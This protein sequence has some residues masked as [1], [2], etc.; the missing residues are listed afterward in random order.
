MFCYHFAGIEFHYWRQ[1]RPGQTI[2]FSSVCKNG[3][4]VVV[5]AKYSLY[6]VNNTE[7]TASL[8]QKQRRSILRMKC[9]V[10]MQIKPDMCT[11]RKVPWRQMLSYFWQSRCFHVVSG[12]CSDK[13][14][15]FPIYIN[16]ISNKNHQHLY[17]PAVVQMYLAKDLI[18]MQ[19]HSFNCWR[20][21]IAVA[22]HCS[23]LPNLFDWFAICKFNL[24]AK[25]ELSFNAE[26]SFYEFCTA[27]DSRNG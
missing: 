11:L 26:T 5:E 2:K 3:F 14:P 10:Y 7:I 27:H 16:L 4:A 13:W 22:S 23:L 25:P 17:K 15:D 12:S 9:C 24:P 21:H 18:I 8:Q 20:W 19:E 6:V 1:C